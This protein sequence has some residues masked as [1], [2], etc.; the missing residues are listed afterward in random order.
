MLLSQTTKWENVESCLEYLRQ[1]NVSIDETKLFDQYHS[2]CEFIE[3]QLGTN[4]LPYRKMMTHE[5]WAAY[6]NTCSTIELFSEL[7]KIAV[8]LQHHSS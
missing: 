4:A 5:R 8:L 7:L 2:L 6:F 3:T 1:K